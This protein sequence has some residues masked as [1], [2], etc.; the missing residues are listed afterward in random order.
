MAGCLFQVREFLSKLDELMGKVSYENDPVRA[1]KPGLQQRADSLLQALLMRSLLREKIV[2]TI[3]VC[4]VVL[5]LLLFVTVLE[6]PL[7]LRLSHQCLKGKDPWCSEQISNSQSRPGQCTI[8]GMFCPWY[9]TSCLIYIF[10]SQYMVY[11][12]IF[13]YKRS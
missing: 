8:T 2:Y 3:V 7:W 6:V 5:F 4:L 12:T 1:Q 11:I 9:I 13:P 10:S